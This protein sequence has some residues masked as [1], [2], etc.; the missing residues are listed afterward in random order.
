[1]QHYYNHYKGND[2]LKFNEIENG[3]MVEKFKEGIGGVHG[4]HPDYTKNIDD[5]LAEKFNSYVNDGLD[6]STIAQRLH[7]DL[8]SNIA[9]LKNTIVEKS[10][11][12]NNKIND[13][14]L[15]DILNNGRF[16]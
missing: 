9:S 2:I 10:V 6:P 13:L 11:M 7:N 14:D 8:K 16:L 3:I 12:S 5:F 15:T 4:N 1:M